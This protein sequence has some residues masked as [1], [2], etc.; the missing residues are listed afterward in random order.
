M[1]LAGSCCTPVQPLGCEWR[2]DEAGNVFVRRPGLRPGPAVAF[3]S[4]LDSQPDGGAFDGALGVLAGLEIMRALDDADLRTEL[5]LELI[6]WTDEEGARFD[7]SCVGSSVW[8]GALD[9]EHALALNDARGVT[10]GEALASSGQRG[11]MASVDTQLESYFELHIEQGPQLERAGVEI[12]VVQGIVGIRWLE[13]RLVGTQSHAGTTPM[14]ERAD[15]L[16]AAAQIVAAVDRIGTSHGADGRGT[17]C[18]FDVEPN[19]GSVIPGRVRMVVDLR[20]SDERILDRMAA[21]LNL[22]LDQIAPSIGREPV[23]ELWVQPPI[24]F[25]SDLIDLVGQAADELGMTSERMLSGAGHDA[26]YVASRVPTAMI[27]IPCRDGLSHQ[28]QEWSSPE[29]CAGGAAV[30]LQAV[31]TRAKPS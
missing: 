14:D 25:A 23:A 5:P 21:E 19:A 27:F 1:S 3:G 31:L 9:L 11:P 26:G 28:P 2:N 17:V 4:H 7:R 20:H 13:V 30:L 22:A 16:R 24:A 6:I 29:A 10:F 18:V 15:A 8:A 12:G